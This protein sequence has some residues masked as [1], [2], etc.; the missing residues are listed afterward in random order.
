MHAM[1]YLT[2]AQPAEHEIEIRKSRFL[3]LAL[4]VD[5]RAAAQRHVA[6]LK[7]RYGDARHHCWAYVLGDPKGTASAGMDDDGEPSGTAGRPILHTL[8]D[9]SV[10][11]TLIVV[12]RWF[13]GIKLG[14]G[15]LTRA[16][17]QA[18]A[19]V[20]DAADLVAHQPVVNT[21][22]RLDFAQEALMHHW[23]R[24]HQAQWLELNYTDTGIVA[25]LSVPQQHLDALRHLARN[26]GIQLS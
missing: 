3:A 6:A 21:H 11:D 26:H 12:V 23:A 7:Q 19:A 17:R 1:A 8:Q 13:G 24:Q 16:Y 14:A 22:L 2:L 15:G 18:A 25:T 4:P 5:S 9:R 10:G 20:L